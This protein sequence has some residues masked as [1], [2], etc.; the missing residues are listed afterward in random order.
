MAF[1][2][3]SRLHQSAVFRSSIAIAFG[4][5]AFGIYLL[6][7]RIYHGNYFK[8]FVWPNLAV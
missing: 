6:S 3:R 5:L 4:L 1:R 2:S 7:L 8:E